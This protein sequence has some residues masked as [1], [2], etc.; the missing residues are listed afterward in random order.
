MLNSLITGLFELIAKLGDMI[1]SPLVSAI[2]L[3][4]PD[5]STF[6][7]SI[8][9]FLGYGFSYLGWVYKA[10]CI[11]KSCMVLVYTIALASVSIV[12][13]TRTFALIVRIY[14]RF[15]I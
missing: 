6:Y 7:N 11:P 13:T 1:L 10:L 5:F 3:L 14:N 15:K 12:V 2:S 9:T 4:I 8:V